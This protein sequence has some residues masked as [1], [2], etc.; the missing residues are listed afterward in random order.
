LKFP[1]SKETLA[2]VSDKKK[3]QTAVARLPWQML[4]MGR[5]LL[6]TIFASRETVAFDTSF[7]CGLYMIVALLSVLETLLNELLTAVPESPA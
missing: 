7:A 5:I 3:I 4:K 1:W 6:L 2:L